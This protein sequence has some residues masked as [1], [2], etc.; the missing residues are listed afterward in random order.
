MSSTAIV[1][2]LALFAAVGFLFVLACLLLGR[3]LRPSNPTAQ[4]VATYECGEPAIGPGSVQFDLRFYV[5]ALVF[6][7]FEVEVALFFP[8]ATVF[9]KATHLRAIEIAQ[10]EARSR[11]KPEGKVLCCDQDDACGGEI[12]RCAQDDVLTTSSAQTL[13][14]AAM[15]DIGVFFAVLL[16]GF[17]YVWRCGDL[18]WVRAVRH[19][20]TAPENTPL[21]LWERGRG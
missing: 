19:P 16:V 2:Y 15:L 4:K 10:G 17:A 11:D 14:L 9:G 1:A 3:L 7:I 18:D 21:S 8:P 20:G 12:L 5:V 6:L 13:C